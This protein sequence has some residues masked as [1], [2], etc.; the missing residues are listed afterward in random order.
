M[1]VSESVSVS[2]TV[3]ANVIKNLDIPPW[4][5]NVALF[6]LFLVNLL[7]STIYR[8]YINITMSLLIK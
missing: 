2:E 3:V 5:R 1:S 6:E 8:M 4:A 7:A